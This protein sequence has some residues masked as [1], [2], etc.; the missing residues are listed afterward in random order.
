MK[1]SNAYAEVRAHINDSNTA[2]TR[3][4]AT[5]AQFRGSYAFTDYIYQPC[6]GHLDL[7][8]E[9]VRLRVYKKTNWQH[10]KY[11]LVHKR[12]E[13]LEST[14]KTIVHKEFDTMQQAQ[15]ALQGAAYVF[16]FSFYRKGWQ[17]SFNDC[18]IFVEEIEESSPTIEII[19]PDKEQIIDL[20]KV[21]G[22]TPIVTH[23]IP[24]LMQQT[25]F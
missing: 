2:Q 14:K 24:Y 20:F 9:F 7:D 22:A 4:H 1:A 13:Q 25:L 23:S 17:F 18:Q 5:G 12:Q 16:D 8:K 11:V 15:Q 6:A 3:L 19:A 10:K 21:V